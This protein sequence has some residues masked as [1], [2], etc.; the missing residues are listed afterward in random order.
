VKWLSSLGCQ[1]QHLKVWKT[2]QFR[3]KFDRISLVS[4]EKK[5]IEKSPSGQVFYNGLWSN[6][7]PPNSTQQ[8]TRQQQ[9][10]FGPMIRTWRSKTRKKSWGMS[11]VTDPMST[12]TLPHFPWVGASFNCFSFVFFFLNYSYFCSNVTVVL[13]RTRRCSSTSWNYFSPSAC[14]GDKLCKNHHLIIMRFAIH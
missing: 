9:I 12:L 8:P 6:L 3:C 13:K 2:L 10:E 7:H 5:K 11:P 14:M 1:L 4:H